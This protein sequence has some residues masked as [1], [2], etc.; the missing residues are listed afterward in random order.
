MEKT[1]LH[2]ETKEVK[3]EPVIINVPWISITSPYALVCDSYGSRRIRIVSRK[4]LFF[5]W[6]WKITSIKWFVKQYTKNAGIK[7]TR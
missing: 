7:E 5:Y 3:I 4:K 1:N 2:L 6:M